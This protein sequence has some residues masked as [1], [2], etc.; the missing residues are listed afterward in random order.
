MLKVK[1]RPRNRRMSNLWACPRRKDT[2]LG[3]VHRGASPR[4]GKLY[5]GIVGNTQPQ[6]EALAVAMNYAS[7]RGQCHFRLPFADLARKTWQFQDQLGPVGYEWNGNH[8]QGRRLFLDMAPW[9]AAVY[10]LT[11]RGS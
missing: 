2:F 11:K 3:Q 8:M 5:G 6:G 7:N 10:A 9:Q 4:R 1:N